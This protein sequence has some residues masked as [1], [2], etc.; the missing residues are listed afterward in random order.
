MH[1]EREQKKRKGNASNSENQKHHAEFKLEQNVTVNLW[2]CLIS[3]YI[4]LFI[5]TAIILIDL[6]CCGNCCADPALGTHY[7]HRSKI[8]SNANDSMTIAL[9]SISFSICGCIIHAHNQFSRCQNRS[10]SLG[11]DC[12]DAKCF[13][14]CVCVRDWACTFVTQFLSRKNQRT[15]CEAEI[16][17]L[18]S[19]AENCSFF[20]V[21]VK[22]AFQFRIEIT[23]THQYKL[24]SNLFQMR[25][26]HLKISF[27]A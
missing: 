21:C 25:I 7:F 11:C 26:E 27:L 1:L 4:F 19:N 23:A 20:F 6:S 16:F 22:T 15:W 14:M 2:V 10:L 12:D 17:R 13:V 3:L 24:K 8:K 18:Q 5:N 9:F